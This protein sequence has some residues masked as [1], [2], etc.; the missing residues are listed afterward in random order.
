MRKDEI[1]GLQK[2]GKI[3]A[4]TGH[5]ALKKDFNEKKLKLLFVNLIEKG[6]KVFLCGMAVGFDTACCKVLSQL[7]LKYDIKIVACVPFIGQERS[8]S[9][10]QKEEYYFLLDECD[11]KVI[12]SEYS[13]K[14]AYLERNRVMVDNCDL[15]VSYLYENKGGTFYTVNYAKKLNK[16]I[17]NFA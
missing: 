14:S 5:R 8:F 3:C 16:E 7:K 2:H 1:I 9:Y 15:L 17:I 11:E 12:V 13:V 6:Y 10:E 4:L